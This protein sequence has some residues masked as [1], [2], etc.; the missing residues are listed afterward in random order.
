MFV[1][2]SLFNF[3]INSLMAIY[4]LMQCCKCN[5]SLKLHLFSFSK[6]KYNIYTRLCEH[7]NVV[8]SFTTKYKF[9]SLGWYIILEVKVQCRKCQHNYYNFGQITFNAENYNIDLM[10]NCCYNVFILS[11]DGS[12]FLSDGKGYLLQKKL[13]ENEEKFRI[14]QDEKRKKE[15]EEEK[16]EKIKFDLDYIDDEYDKM[17]IKEDNKIFLDLNFDAKEEIEKKINFQYS[18]I[19]IC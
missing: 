6:N 17:I 18:K 11:V 7:F 4:V 2:N 13:K 15:E 5:R 9:F 3:F 19:N 12:K 16:T 8:Y 1:E 14:E 10:H